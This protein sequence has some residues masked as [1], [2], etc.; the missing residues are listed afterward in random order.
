MNLNTN[1]FAG[2]N[3]GKKNNKDMCICASSKY[4]Y[5]FYCTNIYSTHI[6]HKITITILQ[7]RSHITILKHIYLFFFIHN[8]S[9]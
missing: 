2:Y 7:L 6:H 3:I 8:I 9:Y 4:G 5:I 1:M